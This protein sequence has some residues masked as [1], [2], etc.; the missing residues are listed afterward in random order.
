M[1]VL[2]IWCWYGTTIAT[3]QHIDT[4][5]VGAVLKTSNFKSKL[6]LCYCCAVVSI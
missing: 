3:W 6:G 2:L 5:E 1:Y 4:I